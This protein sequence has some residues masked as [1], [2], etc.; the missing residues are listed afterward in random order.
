M[1]Q[2]QYSLTDAKPIGAFSLA[3]AEPVDSPEMN[4][5]VVNG[6]KVPLDGLPEDIKAQLQDHSQQG[7]MLLDNLKNIGRKAISA[8]PYV[9]GAVGGALG[10][11]GGVPGAMGG[12]ALVGAGGEAIKQLANRAIGEEAPATAGDAATAIAKQ[13][14]LQG[15]SEGVG[16]AVGAGM[17]AAAPWLMQK[18][19]KPTASVLNEYRTT[20]PKLVQTLL[21][22]G[23]SVTQAGVDK[24]QRLFDATNNDIK[25]AIAG[26]AGTIDKKTVA[27]RAALTA[28]Q[29][30]RQVNPAADLQS[31]GDT[32]QEFINHPVFKGDLTIPE[33]QAMKQGTYQQVGKKYG[34]VSSA[35]I[36]TQKA[37]A[38]GL[39]EEIAAEV[40]GIGALNE[41]DSDLMAALDATGRR[42][43]LSGNKDPVG[44]AWV[45][46]HPTTFLA[47]LFDRSPAVKSLV[48]RGLYQS[49][50]TAGRVSPQLLRAAVAALATGASSASPAPASSDSTIR[51]PNQ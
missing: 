35:S 41:R 21:D 22:E 43:A 46:A 9:G 29:V 37:L 38:R 39:K 44:F 19:L 5:A 25:A 26:S 28:N 7:D 1:P 15:S 27:A 14:A 18:A 24:L 13:S 47:A 4:F 11:V 36:E 32:V 48:A 12:A 42:V 8:L 16:A 40:P 31:V 45:A 2:G 23:V 6:Q 51:P 30:S 33:A 17:K 34:E 49:A 20:A 50:A 3:D 10:A